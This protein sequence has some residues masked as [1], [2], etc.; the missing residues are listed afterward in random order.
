V[1][2]TGT[3]RRMTPG[4]RRAGET[5]AVPV[6]RD[7]RRA[8]RPFDVSFEARTAYDFIISATL[9]DARQHDLPI[10]ERTWLDTARG[11]LSAPDRDALDTCFDDDVP[12]VFQGLASLIVGDPSVKTGADVVVALD[13]AGPRGIAMAVITDLV[14]PG[15]SATLV[16]RA[17]DGEAEALA[18]LEPSLADYKRDSVRGF[19]AGLEASIQQM[20]Q[21]LSAWLVPFAAIEDRVGRLMMADVASRATSNIGQSPEAVIERTTGGL[22][23]M[24][25]SHVRR[26]ILAPSFVGRPYNYIYQGSDWRLFCYP[27]SDDILEAADG[28]TPP[29]SMVRLYRALGDPTRMRVLKLLVGRDWY[30]TELATHVELS[31]PTM[32][33]HLAILRAAGLV[34]VTEEGALTYYSLRRERL[35]EAGLELRHYLG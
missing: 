25:E 31:K 22:R 23:F 30:L 34:T 8:A 11:T 19:L 13:A 14:A 28:V 29:A 26:V 12:T 16:A 7:M 21:S 24:P 4:R 10:E 15:T 33:H 27:I 17:V 6:V 35:D 20:R 1:T 2:A 32:K 3:P 9:G 5:P 18:E